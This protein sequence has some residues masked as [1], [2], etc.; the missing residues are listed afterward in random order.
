MVVYTPA[1]E[2]CRAAIDD[3]IDGDG[4]R[5]RFPCWPDHHPAGEPAPLR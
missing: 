2:A 1:D 5:G 3:M 4:E